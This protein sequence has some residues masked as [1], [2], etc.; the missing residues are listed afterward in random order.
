MKHQV[1]HIYLVRHGQ[2][3]WNLQGLLQGHQDI[4]LNE[5]GRRQARELHDFFKDIRLGAV[6]ASDLARARQTA[7]II[8][9]AHDQ[10]VKTHQALRERYFAPAHPFTVAQSIRDIFVGIR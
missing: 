2:T 4:Q 3:D 6:Y 7:E 1:C 5:A 10:P 8:A 9:A